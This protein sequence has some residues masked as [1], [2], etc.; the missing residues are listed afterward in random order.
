MKKLSI[1][2]LFLFISALS[3]NLTNGQIILLRGQNN[4][5]LPENFI[6]SGQYYYK[7][8]YNY[9]NFYV[10]T[11]EYVNGN[12]K[13]QITIS[14]VVNYHE[15]DS[16]LNLDFY[17]DGVVL[18]YRKY[19]NN[20]LIFE[21]PAYENPNFYCE[22]GHILKGRIMDYGRLTRTLYKDP[23]NTEVWRQGGNPI[24]PICRITK[25]PLDF[26]K[27]KFNLSLPEADD[28]DYQTY[29]GQPFFS[30]PNDIILTK[31]N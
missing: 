13:F 3:S 27:V 31:V 24:I 29:N 23:F 10:G 21:S 17:E 14:K 6:S 8:V 22:E 26:D 4:G 11:W 2:I 12:E 25:H 7:D 1:R 28:Y 5:P 16:Y 20:Q 18:Q 19:L 15:V 30:I 9:L